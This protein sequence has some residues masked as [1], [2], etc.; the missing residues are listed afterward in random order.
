MGVGGRLDTGYGNGVRPTGGSGGPIVLA[1]VVPAL[2]RGNE[3][4]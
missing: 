4:I 3:R 1:P 2:A